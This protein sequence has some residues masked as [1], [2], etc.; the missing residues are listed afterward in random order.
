MVSHRMDEVSKFFSSFDSEPAFANCLVSSR[1]T[2]YGGIMV[3]TSGY[4]GKELRK[5][6]LCFF[7]MI[8]CEFVTSEALANRC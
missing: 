5:F 6:V 3:D 2:C 8:I 7:S 4:G 1:M